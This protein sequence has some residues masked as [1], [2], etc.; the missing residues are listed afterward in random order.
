MNIPLGTPAPN[1]PSRS[2]RN[3]TPVMTKVFGSKLREG[4]RSRV[5]RRRQGVVLTAL[6]TSP[7][8]RSAETLRTQSSWCVHVPVCRP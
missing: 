8:V 2:T 1:V 4:E 3:T 5:A 7:K 6:E